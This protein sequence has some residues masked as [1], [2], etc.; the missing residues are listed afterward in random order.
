MMMYAACF[1]FFVQASPPE[2]IVPWGGTDFLQYYA[3]N[4]MLL[5]KQNPYDRELNQARQESYGRTGRMEMF[6]PPTGLLPSLPLSWLTFHQAIVANIAINIALLVICAAC[7]TWL[8]FSGR[9]NYLPQVVLALP[10]WLPCLAVVAIG[11]TSAWPFAGITLWLFFLVRGRPGWAGAFLALTV[12]KPHLGLMGGML[13]GGY[14][15]RY[16]QGKMIA[17]FLLALAA[18]FGLTLWLR[19]T[20][21]QDYLTAIRTG[22]P[23][24]QIA[25]A[26]LD[27]FARW[28]LGQFFGVI[29]WILWAIGILGAALLGLTSPR[30]QPFDTTGT[31]PPRREGIILRTALVCMATVAVVPYAFS[32]DF[33]FLLPGFILAV[34]AWLGRERYWQVSLAVWL[35]LELW[36]VA[37]RVW[38]WNEHAYWIVPWVGLASLPFA[39]SFK[40]QSHDSI[41]V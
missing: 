23:P 36:M 13:A 31:F 10:L 3:A 11:Q 18:I 27:G 40:P 28:Y 9:W 22:P 1:L 4:Q 17:A 25:T 19:P 7:W 24:T 21:W 12:I 8:L 2:S 33:V 14:A 6:T 16:R 39:L 41:R 29:S 34:G 20:I 26:T 5:D 15:I 30:W 32:M 37:G 38:L 35:G